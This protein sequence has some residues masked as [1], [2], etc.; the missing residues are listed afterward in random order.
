MKALRNL[1]IGVIGSGKMGQALIQGLLARGVPRRSIRTADASAA[2]RAQ[3]RRRFRVLV[4]DGN[5]AVA[6]HSDVIILAVKPQ[7]FPEVV[8]TLAR[9]LTRR[10]LVI[11]IAAGITIRWLEARVPKIPII[12]VMPNLPATVGCAFSAIAAGRKA[13]TRH[14]AI[15]RALFGSVG[16]VVELPERHFDAIT[17]VSGS[18]PVYVFFLVHAWERAARA[19]G[20]PQEVARQAIRRTLEG[21]GRLL[22]ASG[23]P[24]ETLMAKVASK[25]G[26]TEAALKVLERRRVLAHFIEALR[27]AARRSKE[28]SL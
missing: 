21:S 16:D 24:P 17:A 18:G 14:R 10:P 11:S 22:E 19:L 6:R 15:A 27:A 9:E 3:V 4:T 7:Q 2:M 23:E 1:T 26:T 8:P 5:A 20:L 28:L 12:R 13:T 25:R